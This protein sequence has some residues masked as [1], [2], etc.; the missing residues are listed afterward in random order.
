LG[1]FDASITTGNLSLLLTAT[2]STTVVK[3]V[4]TNIAV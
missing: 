2:N 4:R 1:T 3:M